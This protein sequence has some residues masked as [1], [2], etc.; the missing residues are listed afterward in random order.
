MKFNTLEENPV[1]LDLVF[2]FI[3]IILTL[4]GFSFLTCHVTFGSGAE[5]SNNE[6]EL[7]LSLFNSITKNFILLKP[8]NK[9]K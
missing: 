3:F 2:L 7:C 4:L 1:S 5:I 8:S 9:K 6:L